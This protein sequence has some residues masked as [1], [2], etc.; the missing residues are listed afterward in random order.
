M[1]FAAGPNIALQEAVPGLGPVMLALSILGMPEFY[2][3]VLPLVLW[4]YDRTLGFRL[5]LLVPVSVAVNGALKIF[6]HAPRPYW[7]SP[8]VKALASETTFGVPS[9]A[10]QVSLTFLG[11]IAA[12]ARKRW[13]WALAVVLVLLVAIARMYLGVHF[14]EDIIGGW[15][16]GLII[17]VLFLVFEDP[18]ARRLAKVP[19]PVRILLA[20]G[21]SCI[22][23]AAAWAALPGQGWQLPPGWVDMALGQ[24]GRAIDPFSFDSVLMS[25]GLLFGAS[26]GAVLMPAGDAGT[27]GSLRRKA[28]RYIAGM[29]VFLLIWIILGGLVKT[30]GMSGSV[31]T[32]VRAAAGGIWITAGAPCMFRRTGLD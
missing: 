19:G 6:F 11:Y 23:V 14:L 26:A 5:L 13:A 17:L 7:V 4:C 15:I 21:T 8:A 1:E 12:H 27:G 25:A 3:V 9:A 16:V 28:A 20:F 22:M 31:M 18:V 10:A 32:Y 30:P 24:T 2:L 29:V